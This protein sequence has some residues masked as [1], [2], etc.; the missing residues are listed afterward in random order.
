MKPFADRE[1]RAI[2][3]LVVILTLS[4]VFWIV[5][6]FQPMWFM[7]EPDLIVEPP[8]SAAEPPTEI[9]VHVVGEVK[10]PGLYSLPIGARVTDALQAAGGPTDDADLDLLN[11][12]AVLADG[13]QV[14][15]PARQTVAQAAAPSPGST[16][17]PIPLNLATQ[18][19]LE[20]IP[21]IGPTMAQRIL[22]YRARQGGFSS[23]EELTEVRGIGPKTLERLREWLVIY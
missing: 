1:I 23:I 6:H 13:R 19:Q 2:I 7:G 11:Q 14:R 18:A 16:R 20:Q 10:H 22:E 12:A 17:V 3:L 9:T 4:S 21:G 8:E 15:V 5:R